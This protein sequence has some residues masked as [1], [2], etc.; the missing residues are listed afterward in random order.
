MTQTDRKH[1]RL[2]DGIR[3]LITDRLQEIFRRRLTKNGGLSLLY[4]GHKFLAYCIVRM[5]YPAG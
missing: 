4:P 1:R 5:L 3:N 2:S